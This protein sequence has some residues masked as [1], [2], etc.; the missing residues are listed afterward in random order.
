MS[1]RGRIGCKFQFSPSS[2]TTISRNHRQQQWKWI[3]EYFS[4]I[5][6][7]YW[8]GWQLTS[9]GR[10][11]L[12]GFEELLCMDRRKCHS[13]ITTFR[14]IDEILRAMERY[15]VILVKERVQKD[16]RRIITYF[17]KMDYHI[18]W[19]FHNIISRSDLDFQICNIWRSGT[20]SFVPITFEFAKEK[21]LFCGGYWN[22]NPITERVI[23]SSTVKLVQLIEFFHFAALELKSIWCNWMGKNLTWVWEMSSW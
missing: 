18:K 17:Y 15:F 9:P 4:F 22:E 20:P 19:S 8:V 16:G 11:V 5:R 14:L 3:G 6:N 7:G 1:G 12:W 2:S 10:V 23:I 21:Q 13:E